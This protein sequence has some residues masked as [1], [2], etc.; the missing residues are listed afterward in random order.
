VSGLT[1]YS[2]LSQV[3]I[4]TGLPGSSSASNPS[5]TIIFDST[6]FTNALSTN[7]AA[8]KNLATGTSGI[9]TQLQSIVDGALLDDP[10]PN[11]DGLFA[12]KANS[13]AA[14]IEQL[15]DN[16]D[17]AQ[18]R[19]DKKEQLLRQRFQQMEAAI[20]RANAQGSS[21]AGLSA[22]LAANNGRK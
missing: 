13:T 1:P 10:D 17:A 7:P 20:A 12:S 18:E 11:K 21:L 15:N 22:Q 2:T 4:S 14:Q 5:S 19:L 3:G 16:I 6:A 9:L 8:L